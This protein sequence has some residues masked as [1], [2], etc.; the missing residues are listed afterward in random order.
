[1]ID[2]AQHAFDRAPV[3]HH[4]F[5]DVMTLVAGT[6]VFLDRLLLGLDHGFV[7]VFQDA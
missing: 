3:R 6:T 4:A 2:F 5:E 7:N 1:M